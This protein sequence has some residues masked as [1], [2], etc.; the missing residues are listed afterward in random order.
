MSL[1]LVFQMCFKIKLW[2]VQLTLENCSSSALNCHHLFLSKYISVGF[3]TAI[4]N[5]K[6]ILREVSLGAHHFNL[7]VRVAYLMLL[8]LLTNVCVTILPKKKIIKQN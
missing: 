2:F 8:Y 1:E 3:S 6:G 4:G 5:G 7:W